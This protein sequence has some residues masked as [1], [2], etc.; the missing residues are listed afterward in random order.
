MELPSTEVLLRHNVSGPR[1]TSYP[2]VPFW[3]RDLN[4]QDFQ[5]V[6]KQFSADENDKDVALYVHIPFCIKRCTFCGCTVVITQ[7]PDKAQ[8]YLEQLFKEIDAKK[9]YFKNKNIVE[10]HLG[11]GTPTHLTVME[12]EALQ[13][14]LESSFQ[15]KKGAD[16]S[17]EIHPNVTSLEQL[18]FL[19][20]RG[21]NRVSMGVQDV[22]EEVQDAINR[23]QTIEQTQTLIE[24]SRTIGYKS[25]NIDLI[26]GLP[27]QTSEKFKKTMDCVEKWRPDRLAVYSFAHLPGKI[28]QQVLIDTTTL[29]SPEEKFKI[30]LLTVE[31]LTK[32]GYRHMGMDHF[33]LP[34][35]SLSVAMDNNTLHR[36]FMGYTTFSANNM[37]SLGMSAIG[38]IKNVFYQNSPALD[39]YNKNIDEGIFPVDRSMVLSKDDELRESIIQSLMCQ[40]EFSISDIERDHHII[41]KEYFKNALEIFNS[42]EEQGF[43]KLDKQFFKVLPLGRFFIRNICMAFDAYLKN[44]DVSGIVFSKTI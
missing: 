2:T 43:V 13:N 40:F 25:V 23:H 36:N 19:F 12:L 33:A 32:M 18:Q 24:G 35:D 9:K 21:Y 28:K 15:F 1:Y 34:D 20:D 31:R 11:G 8:S 38:R 29:P 17:L 6:L 41:F 16:K 5:E 14:K 7:M 39:D 42:F 26:Y 37:L 44:K 22:D 30:Y 3:N 10:L 4:S 27:H